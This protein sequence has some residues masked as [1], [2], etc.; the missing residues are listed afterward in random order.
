MSVISYRTKSVGSIRTMCIQCANQPSENITNIALNVHCFGTSNVGVPRSK[1]LNL[2]NDLFL[3]NF[4]AKILQGKFSNLTA[5]YTIMHILL[6]PQHERWWKYRSMTN[7][8]N[9]IHFASFIFEHCNNDSIR[10]LINNSRI[11]FLSAA[12]YESYRF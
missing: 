4:Q 5:L 8:M 12:L 3:P 10:F 1:F 2:L 9:V 6:N 7:T 11:R